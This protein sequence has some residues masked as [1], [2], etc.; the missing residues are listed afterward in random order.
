M[1]FLLL[2]RHRAD[3]LNM[4]ST[5]LCSRNDIVANISVLVAAAGVAYFRSV[6]PDILV[7]GMIAALF[8]RT[9]LTVLTES[10][11]EYRELKLNPQ[12]T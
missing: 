3:D 12:R 11:H 4:R 8:L 2:L 7:G 1:C 9:A 6:W 10:L 5:W